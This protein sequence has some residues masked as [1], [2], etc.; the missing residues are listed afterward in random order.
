MELEMQLGK[1]GLTEDFIKDIG[2]RFEKYRNASMKISVLKSARESKDDVKKYAEE[3]K[4][5]LG[6]KYTYRVIGFSIILRKWRKARV[7]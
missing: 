5:K 7:S 1:K 2:K 3:I 6:E 4:D